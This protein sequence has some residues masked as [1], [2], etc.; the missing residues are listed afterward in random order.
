MKRNTKLAIGGVV[1]FGGVVLATNWTAI[2]TAMM[3]SSVDATASA[4]VTQVSGEFA[5]ANRYERNGDGEAGDS[6]SFEIVSGGKLI[7]GDLIVSDG[8][9]TYI[10]LDLG[11][12]ASVRFD[13]ADFALGNLFGDSSDDFKVTMEEGAA[14]FNVPERNGHDLALQDVNKNTVEL[15]SNKGK[16]FVET[17]AFDET[18]HLFVKEGS[19][20]LTNT[21][22]DEAT[23]VLTAGQGVEVNDD[24]SFSKVD[25]Q[26]DWVQAIHW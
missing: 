16:W 26:A 10:A 13:S 25:S 18:L 21:R 12:Q 6:K 1:A 3:T 24:A 5:E 11:D 8:A 4:R 17:S 15:A 22:G 9:E 23:L 7:I 14:V 20:E 19:V 2:M